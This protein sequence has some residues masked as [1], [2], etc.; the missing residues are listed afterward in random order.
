M[1][2]E[3]RREVAMFGE[4]ERERELRGLLIY[5]ICMLGRGKVKGKGIWRE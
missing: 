5:F 3:S 1:G 4:R 2:F